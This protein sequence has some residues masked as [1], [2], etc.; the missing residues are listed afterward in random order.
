MILRDIRICISGAEDNF[1]GS[2]SYLNTCWAGMD[3]FCVCVVV[4][5]FFFFFFFFFCFFLNSAMT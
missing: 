4:D 3:F 5:F 2:C 1:E